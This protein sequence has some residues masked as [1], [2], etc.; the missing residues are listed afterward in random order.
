MAKVKY[1]KAFVYRGV[2]Y[3]V[4]YAASTKEGAEKIREGLYGNRNT[5]LHHDTKRKRWL[6]GKKP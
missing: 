3:R 1:L 4:V 2:R 5:A 6:I